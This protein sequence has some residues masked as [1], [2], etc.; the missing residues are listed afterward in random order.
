IDYGAGYNPRH[1][2]ALGIYPDTPPLIQRPRID[3]GLGYDPR[4]RP[5]TQTG[6]GG[7]VAAKESRYASLPNSTPETSALCQGMLVLKICLD[8]S[9]GDTVEYAK[10]VE[11]SMSLYEPAR[12]YALPLLL[13]LHCKLGINPIFKDYHNYFPLAH[14]RRFR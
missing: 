9:R 6:H 8:L 14:R 11:Y 4:N 5:V 12:R 7:H 3:Y 1:R 2:P 13:S 10:P